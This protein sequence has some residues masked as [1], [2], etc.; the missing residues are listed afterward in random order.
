M[1][2]YSVKTLASRA[3][4]TVRNVRAYQDKGLLPQPGRRGR[5]AVYDSMHLARLRFIVRL[6]KRGYTLSSIKDLLDAERQGGGPGRSVIGLV[7]E[8]A[9][10]WS[11]ESP[12]V[13]TRE[14][15]VK[16]LGVDDRVALASA[17]ELGL[18]TSE[19][20]GYRVVSPRLVAVGAQLRAI[21]V[22]LHE[23]MSPLKVLR[24]AME[25]VAAQFVELAAKHIPSPK[26]KRFPEA[27][28]IVRRLRPLAQAAVEAELA[29]AMRLEATRILEKALARHVNPA[30]APKTMAKRRS[31]K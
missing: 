3:G 7:T 14:E 19:G 6:L 11:D 31:S 27:A 12:T 20:D 8:V 1:A 2:S 23:V 30:R 4:S 22:P 28:D 5:H 15:L 9:G 16:M 10:P 26:S 18:L 21:G 24:A 29:R 17:L 13:V 25:V